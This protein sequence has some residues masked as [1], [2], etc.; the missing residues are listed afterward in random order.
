MQ[1]EIFL[2]KTDDESIITTIETFKIS[3]NLLLKNLMSVKKSEIEKLRQFY[4]KEILNGLQNEIKNVKR[5]HDLYK[6]YIDKVDSNIENIIR[7]I[8]Q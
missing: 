1:D 4:R 2:E 3:R 5:F 6:N 8:K 7:N